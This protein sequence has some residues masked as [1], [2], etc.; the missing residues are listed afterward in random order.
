VTRREP[1]PLVSQTVG[2]GLGTAA[3]GV[4]LFLVVVTALHDPGRTLCRASGCQSVWGLAAFLGIC[5]VALGAAFA[6]NLC[7]LRARRKR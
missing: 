6:R 2:S 4:L 5:T 1:D 7:A 3:F